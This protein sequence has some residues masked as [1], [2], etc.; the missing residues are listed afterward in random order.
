MQ[1]YTVPIKEA[2]GK[3]LR[4]SGQ[5]HRNGEF[6]TRMV[7]FYPYGGVAQTLET[8]LKEIFL[9]VGVFETWPFPHILKT[10]DFFLICG[11]TRIWEA[12]NLDGPYTLVYQGTKPGNRWTVA[13]FGNY[14]VLTNG[15]EIIERLPSGGYGV[16]V[17]FPKCS[18]V[19]AFAGQIIFGGVLVE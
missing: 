10:R 15:Q 14:L 13:D 3:G 4:P 2:L 9:G 19:T 7:G 11:S 17:R 8:P 12:L 16:S 18:C 6:L 5:E 1:E